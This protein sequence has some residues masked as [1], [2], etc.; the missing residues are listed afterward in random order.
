LPPAAPLSTG[1]LLLQGKQAGTKVFVDGVLKGFTQSDGSLKLPLDP[2]KYTI[3]LSN[4]PQFKDQ[5]LSSVVVVANSQ[6]AVHYELTPAP[7]GT[8]APPVETDAYLTLL[9]NPGASVQVDGHPQGKTGERGDLIVQMKPG[10]HVLSLALDG[11]RPYSENITVR[12]G[13]GN[14]KA[15]LLTAIPVA[16]A[17]APTPRVEP[18][19]IRSF[20]ATYQEIEQGDATTLR[21]QTSNAS[22]VSID[23]GI[24]RVDNSGETTVRPQSNTTYTLTARGSSGTQQRPLNIGVRPKGR[25]VEPTPAPAP[26]SPQV[27]DQKG[28][29]QAALNTFSSAFNAHDVGRIRA[30]WPAMSAKQAKD[31]DGS[32]KAAQGLKVAEQCPASTLTISGD[33]AEWACTEISTYISDG[34]PVSSPHGMHF[35]FVRKDGV[36]IIADRR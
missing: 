27:V 4:P 6:K 11:Y 12:P 8:V 28:P 9:S 30:I 36:W 20:N 5:T 18:V 29:V 22:E 16:P 26:P 10:A 31:L 1:E 13:S 14:N 21:W 15:V 35:T 19:E 23:N 2:G 32:F 33:R 3:L 34:K 7:A 24:G 17:P 25:P